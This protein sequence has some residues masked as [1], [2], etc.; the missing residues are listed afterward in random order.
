MITQKNTSAAPGRS[1]RYHPAPSAASRSSAASHLLRGQGPSFISIPARSVDAGTAQAQRRAH[2]STA[3]PLRQTLS[4]ASPP[5]RVSRRSGRAPNLTS[6][7]SGHMGAL[8]WSQGV[9]KKR[10]PGPPRHQ[11]PGEMCRRHRHR[12]A[13]RHLGMESHTTSLSALP[14]RHRRRRHHARRLHHGRRPIA[15]LSLRFSDDI[16]RPATFCGVVR[17]SALPT[18]GR[19]TVGARG[20]PTQPTATSSSTP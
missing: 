1:A 6:S 18:H 10:P 11:G 4:T 5:V 8:L 13:G 12:R 16:P 3:L 14:G 2:G 19:A 9:V 20:T 17:A 15:N 7:S